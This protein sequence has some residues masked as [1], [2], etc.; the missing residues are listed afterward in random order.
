[1]NA[2]SNDSL[3]ASQLAE[4]SDK[5]QAA[6]LFSITT[7][8][9]LWAGASNAA[10]DEDPDDCGYWDIGDITI[11]NGTDPANPGRQF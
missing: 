5:A 4:T 8:S 3:T 10:G 11:P 2:Q 7:A 6:C 1:M 9:G